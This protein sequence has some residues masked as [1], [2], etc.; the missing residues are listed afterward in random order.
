MKSLSLDLGP[1]LGPRRRLSVRREPSVDS[2]LS[3]ETGL[4]WSVLMGVRIVSL[5]GEGVDFTGT[6]GPLEV[7]CKT[8]QMA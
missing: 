3:K 7:T 1:F 5:P 6:V 2:G 4:R 8:Q